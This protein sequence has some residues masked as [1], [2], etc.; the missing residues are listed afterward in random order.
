MYVLRAVL[1]SYLLVE[2]DPVVVRV[3]ELV[4][5]LMVV[6]CSSRSSFAKRGASH[7]FSFLISHHVDEDTQSLHGL[8]STCPHTCSFLLALN[9]SPTLPIASLPP[10]PLL[11]PPPPRA[12]SEFVFSPPLS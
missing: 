12:P 7:W 5:S 9:C 4:N 2:H 3:D 6:Q 10:P 11:L 1:H 8:S